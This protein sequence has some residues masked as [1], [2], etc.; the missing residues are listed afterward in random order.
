MNENS[1]FDHARR[2]RQEL[3]AATGPAANR[4]GRPIEIKLTV[5]K[6]EPRTMLAGDIH[7]LADLAD[8]SL[9]GPTAAPAV[10]QAV[11]GRLSSDGVPLR[12]YAQFDGAAVSLVL[13]ITTPDGSPVSSLEVGD[14]FVLHV[15]AQDLRSD[16]HGVF[17]VYLDISWDATL[18]TGAGQLLY[19]AE[20]E[21]GHDGD[22]NSA[23]AL[24][25][26]G[27]F[28]GSL[29]SG[30][31]LHEVF[32]VPLHAATAGQLVISTD[33][34]DLTPAHDV[35]VYAVNDAVD[36][37]DVIF[38]SAEVTI[39]DIDSSP[40]ESSPAPAEAPSAGPTEDV[41]LLLASNATGTHSSPTI[42]AVPA[43][44][45]ALANDTAADDIITAISDSTDDN[46]IST[47][48]ST[49]EPG[50]DLSAESLTSKQDLSLL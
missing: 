34:A 23:G 13:Q 9:P 31:G 29:E 42:A 8:K 24:D 12:P 45:S 4:Y 28:G 20:F 2:R 44:L 7:S 15:L 37:L 26:V 33:Q 25:E 40:I 36:P 19:A 22:A 48:E 18:A 32:S 49:D 11:S 21:N 3:S 47:Q 46:S 10:E 38:G 16:P 27:A 43:L 14:D 35:L 5:E 6:L 50:E 30:A 1:A 41:S 17:A 39:A